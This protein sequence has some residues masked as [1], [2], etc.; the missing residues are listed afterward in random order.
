MMSDQWLYYTNDCAVIVD[1]AANTRFLHGTQNFLTAIRFAFSSLIP[2][3]FWVT[4][5]DKARYILI[6]LSSPRPLKRY[7]LT[8]GYNKKENYK[9]SHKSKCKEIM[10]DL[11]IILLLLFYLL[12]GWKQFTVMFNHLKEWLSGYDMRILANIASRNKL[13]FVKS[14]MCPSTVVLY[15]W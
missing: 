2:M 10:L 5:Q 7:D 8:R 11:I 14:Y 6:D 1:V 12:V 13:Y 15:L 4:T 3:T 9:W